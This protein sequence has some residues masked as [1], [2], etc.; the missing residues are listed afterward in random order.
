MVRPQVLTP[1][2]YRLKGLR[3][4]QEARRRQITAFAEL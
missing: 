1:E 3:R 2:G 4:W